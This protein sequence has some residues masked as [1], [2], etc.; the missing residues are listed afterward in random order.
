MEATAGETGSVISSVLFGAL[1]ASGALPFPR[2]LYE[3]AIRTGGVAV[4]A[5][6]AGFAAGFEQALK[7]APVAGVYRR[8]RRRPAMRANGWMRGAR[9]VSG[10]PAW[11]HRR[12]RYAG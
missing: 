12:G 11:P 8:E 7:G 10:A 2:E 3:Q 9:D 6:L 4:A 5:N 1:A